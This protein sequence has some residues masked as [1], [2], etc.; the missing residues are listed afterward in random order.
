[1]FMFAYTI[2]TFGAFIGLMI[3]SSQMQLE[4]NPWGFWLAATCTALGLLLFLI[5]QFGKKLAKEEMVSMKAFIV[6]AVEA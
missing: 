4:H 3:A 2:A 1:M 5:A 6:K